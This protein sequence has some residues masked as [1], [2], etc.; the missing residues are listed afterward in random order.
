MF[1]KKIYSFVGIALMILAI[2][3]QINFAE[4]Q[5]EVNININGSS[6]IM[7]SDNQE[8]QLSA[9]IVDDRTMAPI[10]PIFEKFN[11]ELNWNASDN[12]I[13]TKAPNGKI[14]WMQINNNVA[15]VDGVNYNM[16]IGPRIIDG[17]TYVPVKYL[18]DLLG[19]EYEWDGDNRIVSVKA[20]SLMQVTSSLELKETY[21]EAEFIS[22]NFY[23][24]KNKVS[25]NKVAL[26]TVS[27]LN[28][29]DEFKGSIGKM[30]LLKSD[31]SEVN[32][33]MYRFKYFNIEGSYAA[34][35]L[36]KNNQVLSIEFENFTFVEI[37][38]FLNEY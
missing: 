31:F 5:V 20:P 36:E 3:P 22:E 37:E 2:S 26:I 33:I 29:A 12:S 17:K 30:G 32:N 14:I 11:L 34:V 6:I 8:D 15:K 1:K 13:L 25:P 18:F 35:I 38:K 23:I 9:L 21:N 19:V 10:R 7:L 4:S 24:I 16:D 27:K 28:Y